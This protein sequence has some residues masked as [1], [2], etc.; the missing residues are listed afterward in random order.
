MPD[1]AFKVLVVITL[2]ELEERIGIH[3]DNLNKE[4]GNIKTQL[5]MNN[6][7]AEIKYRL[8]RKE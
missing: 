8:R 5:E 3:S 1:K 6:S 4:P 2:T 7:I